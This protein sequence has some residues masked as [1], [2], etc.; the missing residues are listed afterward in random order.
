MSRAKRRKVATEGAD[1]LFPPVVE[2]ALSASSG[3][4]H[5]GPTEQFDP[6]PHLGALTLLPQPGGAPSLLAHSRTL[7]VRAL[8]PGDWSLVYDDEGFGAL[9]S[10]ALDGDSQCI[11]CENI[12][13]RKMFKR[14][15]DGVEMI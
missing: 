3:P 9:V 12:L 4:T 15:S 6:L 2:T 10:E 13:E 14:P 1:P 7:E 11:V 5:F 8:P